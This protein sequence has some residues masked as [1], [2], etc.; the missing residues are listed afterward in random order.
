M[1][2]AEPT[3]EADEITAFMLG[4][5]SRLAVLRVQRDVNQFAQEPLLAILPGVALNELWQMIGTL[6]N[7]LLVISV[8]ILISSLLGLATMLLASMRERQREM[9]V[10]RAVG[11]G[12]V[13]IFFLIQTEALLL[14]ILAAAMS[15]LLVWLGLQ[16]IGDWLSQ[17]YGLFIDSNI[18]NLETLYLTLFVLG[19][20]LLVTFIPAFGAYRRAL[21]TGLS[22]G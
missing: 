14:A 13:V 12:P 21:H 7:L 16:L 1:A 17:H 5:N 6:E 9:A 18:F 3:V 2:G 8:L 19:A 20:T 4:L 10:L 11:A 15:V 22:A